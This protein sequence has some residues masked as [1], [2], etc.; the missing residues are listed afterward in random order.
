M[1]ELSIAQ[2]ILDIVRESVSP[3]DL[4][5]VRVVKLRVGHL[6]GVVP[7]SLDFSFTVLTTDTPLRHARLSIDH[8][9]FATHAGRAS[10]TKSGSSFAPRAEA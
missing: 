2:N 9:P 3:H 8:I 4:P 1:H 7:D 6:A 10:R 5:G